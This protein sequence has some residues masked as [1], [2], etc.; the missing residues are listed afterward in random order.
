MKAITES[1][2]K[3]IVA[4]VVGLI[5]GGKLL[6]KTAGQA[7][8]SVFG[9]L[10]KDRRDAIQSVTDAIVRTLT[11]DAKELSPDDPGRAI[12]A[13][14]N[15]VETIRNAKLDADVLLDC[16]LDGEAVYEYLIKYPAVGIEHASGG[17]Q[18]LYHTYLRRFAETV[19]EAVFVTDTFQRRM[20]R[21]LMLNQNEMKAMLENVAARTSSHST[22]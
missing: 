9:S 14:F 5:P 21:R 18:A 22:K 8:V 6:E 4:A 7:A 13:A 19:V 3:D 1:A 20:F 15:V 10:A 11:Q 17:R 12:S 16:C 2:I